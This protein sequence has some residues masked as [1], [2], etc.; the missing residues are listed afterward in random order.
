MSDLEEL[1]ERIEVLSISHSN[2]KINSSS[3]LV[4]SDDKII[5]ENMATMTFKPE[6][7]KCIP[8]YD[9][10]PNELNE[11]IASAESII[12]T[13]VDNE[14][15][16]NFIN[17]FILRSIMNKLVGNAKIAINIQTVT[18]WTELKATLVRNFSDQRDEI[19]LIRDLVLTKQINENPLQFYDKVINL[20]NLLC[21]YIKSHETTEAGIVIKREL[22]NK[23]ALKTYLAGLKEPLGSAIRAMRPPD[24]QTALFYIHEERNV[25]YY[26]KPIQTP[27]NIVTNKPKFP[28]QP[29]NVQPKQVNQKFPTNAQ[30]FK[31]NNANNNSNQQFQ[32]N[33]NVFKPNPNFKPA[34]PTPM[35]VS[36]RQTFFKPPNFSQNPR[37]NFTSEE[38]FNTETTEITENI[39]D[40]NVGI[41][42][43]TSS[44]L[45]QNFQIEASEI[46]TIP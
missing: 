43:E 18:T 5:V 36:T 37:P 32:K 38:L 15:T 10:N 40:E 23:L 14:N 29:I 3:N 26:Q 9:G 25:R 7:L 22:F 4:N 28:S 13:F 46:E 17:T 11:F 1:I 21:S 2:S 27:P 19:C 31:P 44:D 30:V 45:E 16:G 34:T 20:L 39:Y 35:S 33:K 6:Y 12:E 24:L 42:E 8:Q 41:E